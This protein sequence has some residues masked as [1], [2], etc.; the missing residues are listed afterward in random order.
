M[1][2]NLGQGGRGWS[3]GGHVGITDV[4]WVYISIMIRV[5]VAVWEQAV[6]EERE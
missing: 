6:G 3:W 4:D 2:D 5:H 1:V